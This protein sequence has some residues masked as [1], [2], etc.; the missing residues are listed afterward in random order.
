[1]RVPLHLHQE[2]EEEA[3]L[4]SALAHIMSSASALHQ[5]PCLEETVAPQ[6]MP[7]LLLPSAQRWGVSAGGPSP[8]LGGHHV[9]SRA[10]IQAAAA[11]IARKVQQIQGRSPRATDRTQEN[12]V[13]APLNGAWQPICGRPAGKNRNP[14]AAPSDRLQDTEIGRLGEKG[15]ARGGRRGRRERREQPVHRDLPG[16]GAN[17]T[18][19]QYIVSIHCS[20]TSYQYIAPIHCSNTLYEQNRSAEQFIS[21]LFALNHPSNI[22]LLIDCM[23]QM[24][25]YALG[26]RVQ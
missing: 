4:G 18:S 7:P 14:A 15:G 22:L 6:Q 26:Y 16:E 17:P 3:V 10:V 11:A 2:L 5:T 23:Q 1:M 13:T 9:C 24:H 8:V 20:N 25:I 12:G 21:N 19:L